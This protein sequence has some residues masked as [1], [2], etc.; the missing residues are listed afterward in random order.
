MVVALRVA[1]AV[2][3]V[4]LLFAPAAAET[5][6]KLSGAQIRGRF[7]G[8]DMSDGVHWR[9]SYGRDGS[10]ASLS[11]GKRRSGKWHVEKDQLC[12]D[13][14]TESGGCYE[15]WIAGAKVEFRREGFEGSILEG[16]L[17]KPATANQTA[18]GKHP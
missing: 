8:M 18:K 4:G 1:A 3:L 17:A 9:D 13:L 5:F 11:M 10:L 2:F 6:R 16:E 7:V 12:I 15:V 14:G